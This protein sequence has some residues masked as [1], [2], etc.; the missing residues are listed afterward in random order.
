[1]QVDNFQ[2]NYEIADGPLELA[3]TSDEKKTNYLKYRRS[4]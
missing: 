1:M 4:I 3:A 2:G